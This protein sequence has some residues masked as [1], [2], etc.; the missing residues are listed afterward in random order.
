MIRCIDVTRRLRCGRLHHGLSREYLFFNLQ[1]CC[2][3]YFLLLAVCP[4]GMIRCSPRTTVC[5]DAT[6]RCDGVEDCTMG[7]DEEDCGKKKLHV[8]IPPAKRSFRG[9]Y[10]FQPVRD[11]VIPSFR[12][13]VIPSFR[14]SVNIWTSLL[15]NLSSFCLICFKFSP[16]LYHQTIHVW[17]EFRGQRVSIA[18]VMGLFKSS[19]NMFA[20]VLKV[21]TL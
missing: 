13:S 10:C 20:I 19:Y 6:R 16:H 14:H 3:I 2:I 21:H 11:S 1:K 9:V 12:D 5:I 4:P 17:Y 8:I 7:S 15:N 18:R